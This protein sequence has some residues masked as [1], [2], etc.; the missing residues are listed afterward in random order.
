MTLSDNF[1]QITV[2]F[3]TPCILT[4]IWLVSSDHQYQFCFIQMEKLALNIFSKLIDLHS[5][6]CFNKNHSIWFS[7]SYQIYKIK[8]EI[9]RSFFPLFLFSEFEFC[10]QCQSMYYF[11]FWSLKSIITKNRTTPAKMRWNKPKHEDI[12]APQ[13]GVTPLRN[14]NFWKSSKFNKHHK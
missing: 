12:I 2:F 6:A 11:L 7:P 14:R 9:K 8:N 13:K 5:S 3:G 1:Q 10:Y 4:D